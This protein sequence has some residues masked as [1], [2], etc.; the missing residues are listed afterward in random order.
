MQAMDV[1]RWPLMSVD[2]LR[3]EIVEH[4][5]DRRRMEY[6]GDFLL[7]C[8]PEDQLAMLPI[9]Y[10]FDA[11][12]ALV[13]RADYYRS[14]DAFGAA[15]DFAKAYTH[16]ISNP[17][18]TEEDLDA[19]GRLFLV[20]A[21]HARVDLLVRT[22]A[23]VRD[24]LA[25]RVDDNAESVDAMLDHI[26]TEAVEKLVAVHSEDEMPPTGRD[27]RLAVLLRAAAQYN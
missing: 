1:H 12:P 15:F 11:F 27:E 13:G 8:L 3:N 10:V 22:A 26:A 5:C 16:A 7:A 2:E 24:L 25:L 20:H 17:Q 21:E 9:G 14:A 19:V 23:T 18:H 4:A 6:H